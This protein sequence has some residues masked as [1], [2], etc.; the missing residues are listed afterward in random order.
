[1]IVDT[2]LAKIFGTK[3]QSE[4]KGMWPIV[5]AINELEPAIRQL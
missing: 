4:I 2:I 1:M 3:T 5:A